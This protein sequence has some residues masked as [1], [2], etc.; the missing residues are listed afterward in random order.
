MAV[1]RGAMRPAI[2][3]GRSGGAML[4]VKLSVSWLPTNLDKVGYM[5]ETIAFAVGAGGGC[6]DIFFLWSSISLFLPLC[7]G[8]PDID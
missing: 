6:F 2:N 7:G 3:R 1:V 4:L 8:R 5:Y